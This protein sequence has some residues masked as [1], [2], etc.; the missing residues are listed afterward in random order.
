[1]RAAVLKEYGA[2]PVLE[3]FPDPEPGQAVVEVLAAGLN[4]VDLAKASGTFYDG[5][6]PLPSVAGSEGVGTTEDGRRVYFG[7]CVAPYGPLAQR[8]LIEPG[9]AF[10]VPE[11]L[12]PALA[13]CFGVAGLAGWLAVRWRGAL[14][15]GE[16]VIVLGCTGTVGEVA[17]QAALLGGAGR[18]VAAGRRP[19]GLERARALGAHA[20]VRLGEEEDDD[21]AEALREAAGGAADLV[22]DPLWGAPGRAAMDV[23]RPYGRHVQ[24]GQSAAAELSLPSALIRGR[25]LSIV[26]YTNFAVPLEVRREAYGR[27]TAHA[28]AGELTAE[29]ETFPLD[30]A[31]EAWERQRSGPRA[32]PVVVP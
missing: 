24:L 27:M 21:L 5:S 20:T 2:T 10:A 22:I 30:R 6:P 32:K 9:Q 4:P 29:Y 7:R 13:V 31:P 18:V 26:G 8:T 28:A 17:L 23:L 15:A 3:D 11:A 19:E 14:E 25:P 1:M 12:D 16:T